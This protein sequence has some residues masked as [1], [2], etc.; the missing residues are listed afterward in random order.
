MTFSMKRVN[1]IFIKDWKDLQRNSYIL[2]TAAIP[3]FFAAWLGRIGAD[4]AILASYPV[5][6]A[7]VIAGA[8]IQAAMV[9]EE[10]EKNTLRGLL[11]SPANTLEILVGKSALSAVMTIV[12]ITGSILLSGYR[13]PSLPVFAVSILLGLIIYLAIG[14]ILGLLSRTVM[15]SSII[16]MPVLVVFGMASMV[17]TTI[18][19]EVLVKVIDYLPSEQ[20]NHIWVRLGE[21]EGLSAVSGNMAVLLLW[22]AASFFATMLIYRKNSMDYS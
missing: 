16:G 19:N 11:L 21:G 17:K 14:T 9:A 7:L 8:F 2:F 10:K 6:L 4:S 18:E 13:V 22:A 12:I 3:L 1:A 5:N 20:L 15:E